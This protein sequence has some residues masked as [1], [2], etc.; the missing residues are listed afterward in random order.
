MCEFVYTCIYACKLLG[1]ET[2]SPSHQ[3]TIKHQRGRDR[4]DLVQSCH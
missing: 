2:N 1:V 4:H 3:T